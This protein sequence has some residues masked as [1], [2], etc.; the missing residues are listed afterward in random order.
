MN[1]TRGKV[2]LVGAVDR[3]GGAQSGVFYGGA[4]TATQ[5]RRRRAIVDLK[6]VGGSFKGCGSGAANAAARRRIR[7][8]WG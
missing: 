2:R 7:G 6:L 8:L 5:A 3:N 1:A 4:F